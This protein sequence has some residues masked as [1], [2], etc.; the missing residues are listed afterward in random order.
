MAADN[1]PKRLRGPGSRFRVPGSR[2]EVSIPLK[3]L[4][5][6]NRAYHSARKPR[7]PEG[8]GIERVAGLFRGIQAH[9]EER[10]G[11]ARSNS[12]I[13]S[14]ASKCKEYDRFSV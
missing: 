12:I 9:A 3:Q 2:Y 7:V 1:A 4:L 8:D 13:L 6:A 11:G 14:L 5:R 10:V